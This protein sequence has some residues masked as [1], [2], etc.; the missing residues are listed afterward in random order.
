MR[1]QLSTTCEDMEG[2]PEPGRGSSRISR[3]RHYSPEMEANSFGDFASTGKSPLLKALI[4]VE[5]AANAAAIQLMSFKETL[6]NDSEGSRHSVSDSRRTSRQRNLLLDKLEVFKRINKSVRQQLKELQES[7]ANRLESDRHTDILLEKLTEAEC[8]N[9]LLKRDLNDKERRVEEL[10]DMRNKEMDYFHNIVHMTKSVETTRA[11]LQSQLRSKEAENNRLTVQL[12]GLERSLMT[13][14]LEADDLRREITTLSE[15]AGQEKEALKK[16]TRAQ[17]HRAEKF[18]AAV[19]KCYSQLREKDVQLLEAGAERDTWRRQLEQ[20]ADDREHLEGQID[21][22]KCQIADMT[23]KLQKEREE[24]TAGNEILLQKVENLNTEHGNLSL[25]NATLKASVSALEQ[26]LACS[27]ATVEEQKDVLQKRKEQAEQ[28]QSQVSA[29]QEEVADLRMKCNSLLRETENIREGK[30]AEIKK[31][32]QQLEGRVME[33]EGFTELLRSAKHSLAESQESLRRSEERCADKS[34]SIRQL[35]V[36]MECQRDNLAS[37]LEMKESLHKANSQLQEKVD[38]LQK[39]MDD[40]QQENQELVHKLIGQEEALQYSS[41][42][43][44]QRSTECQALNRQLEA[45]LAD[46]R[47]QVIKVKEKAV[48]REGALQTKILE[49]EAEKRRRENELKQLKINMQSAEKKFDVRLKDL[50]LSLDHSESHKRSIQN[51]VDFL[52]NSYATMFDEGLMPSGF[53]STY[54]LK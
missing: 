21:L 4:D 9:Q 7:E 32:R 8:E 51:Y 3:N 33:L 46:V 14:K 41:R 6:D 26:Q 24:F 53:G 11:H 1:R 37:S 16:A 47:Q 20:S 18:E 29:L 10:M 43:L 35:K 31:V 45:T 42:S 2:S 28:Y 49:L 48:S 50:Q 15:K 5:S 44:E 13:Q 22:L 30:E 36:K 52:K 27:E 23:E 19:D 12:R 38:Y 54:F 39:R 25:D 17:K 34:E 40:M